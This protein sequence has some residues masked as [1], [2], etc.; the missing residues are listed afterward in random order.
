MDYVISTT[1]Y[2]LKGTYTT[3]SLYFVTA[4]FSLPLSMLFA[5]LQFSSPKFVRYIFD[6]YAWIFR[7]TPLILQLIFFYYGLPLMTN[8]MI[9][10]PAFTSAAIT[11]VLN[12]SAYLMEI[13]RAGIESIE[14]GQYEAGFALN[15]SYRQIMT[16]IIL[17]QAVRRVLP[18]L[19]NEA[20]N[21]IKDTALVIVL[22]IGDLMLH[23]RQILTR[24]YKL[25]PF[26]IAAII[27]LLFTS[28]LV[29]V[30][31]QLEKKYVI[32]N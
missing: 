6:I 1:L 15:L 13:F 12:Y 30:F 17:P 7:G 2:L 18:P 26:L 21:L 19:S 8:N 23:A 3:L 28:I 29:F 22:G 25:L 14:K 31:R 9:A 32:R 16:R 5:A 27:Y 24:D 4:I 11:F 20:I 10:F